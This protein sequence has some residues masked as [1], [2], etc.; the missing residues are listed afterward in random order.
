[1]DG[2]NALAEEVAKADLRHLKQETGSDI[3]TIGGVS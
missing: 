2:V 1:M 3:V